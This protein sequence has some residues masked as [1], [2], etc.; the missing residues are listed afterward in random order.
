[1]MAEYANRKYAIVYGRVNISDIGGRPMT[2]QTRPGPFAIR[3][4]NAYVL[5]EEK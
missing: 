1:M 5:A 3:N 4:D 2:V